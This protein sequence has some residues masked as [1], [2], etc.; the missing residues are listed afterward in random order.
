MCWDARGW[1]HS[2]GA[3]RGACSILVE[4][5]E[6]KKKKKEEAAREG[7]HPPPPPPPLTIMKSLALVEVFL[8]ILYLTRTG[9]EEMRFRD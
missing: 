8:Y 7:V 2:C 6:R 9:K 5:K 4:D 3:G 1:G